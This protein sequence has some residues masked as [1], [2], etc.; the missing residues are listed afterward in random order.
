MKIYILTNIT[1]YESLMPTAKYALIKDVLYPLEVIR[2]FLDNHDFKQLDC[3]TKDDFV[4]I[5]TK[6]YSLIKEV[7]RR[8]LR[9]TG[10]CESAIGFDSDKI[11]LR[12]AL[13]GTGV[14]M[15]HLYKDASLIPEKC[16]IFVKPLILED[17]IGIDEHSLCHSA[18]EVERRISFLMHTFGKAPI[19]EDYIDGYDV[20]SGI[21]NFGKS[22][23]ISACRILS[24][25]NSV[26]FM[27]Q[28]VKEKDL[29]RFDL[30][31]NVSQSINEKVKAATIETMNAI[32][33]S[34][35]ARLDFRVKDGI[36]YLIEV[37][38]YPGLKNTGAMYRCFEHLFSYKDFLMKVLST[39]T[40]D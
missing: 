39:A 27:T 35:Y 7:S 8:G 31:E 19:I 37:N 21:I 20:T 15:P 4:L 26:D 38:L 11:K 12:K 32:G 13:V 25:D 14:T 28:K 22:P 17:S 29:R 2:L 34:K 24:T 40:F 36:P 5:E 6:D 9:H 33:A 16:R 1:E 18:K 3:I 30:M 23:I 10:E